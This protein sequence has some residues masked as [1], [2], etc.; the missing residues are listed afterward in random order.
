MN[1]TQYI[2]ILSIGRLKRV[3][4]PDARPEK[5]VARK[6]RIPTR[7]AVVRQQLR[8]VGLSSIDMLRP[9][10]F[11]I[12]RYLNKD[13]IVQAAVVGHEVKGGSV[14]MLVLTTERFIYFN[15]IPLF[16]SIEDIATSAVQSITEVVSAFGI[17][18][19][20]DLGGQQIIVDTRNKQAAQRFVQLLEQKLIDE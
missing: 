18:I 11:S 8:A 3:K 14:V 19:H 9:E 2:S 17:E 13:E 12:V 4:Q 15:Q 20:L 10:T 6:S 1:V 16:S 5:N 7:R